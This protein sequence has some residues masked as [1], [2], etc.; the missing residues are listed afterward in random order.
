[1]KGLREISR[2]SFGNSWMASG[3]VMDNSLVGCPS[4]DTIYLKLH[5]GKEKDMLLC[6]TPDEAKTLILLLGNAL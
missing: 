4:C 1:M 3:E 5:R 2:F 6:I